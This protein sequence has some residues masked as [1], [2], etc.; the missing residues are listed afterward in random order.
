MLLFLKVF[1]DVLL[2]IDKY[3]IDV[4]YCYWCWYILLIIWLGYVLFYFM[5][6]SFNVVVLEIFVNG[7]FSCSDIGLLVILFYIIYGVLK[8]VFGIVSDCLNVCYFMGIGFIVMG[9]INILFGF[10]MLLWVFVVFWVLNVFFQGWGLLVCVCL[11]MVWYLC[12][13]CGGWWVLW[14]MVYNVGGVFIF[15]VMVVV[16]LYYGWCVGMMIVGC[17]VIVV[18]I[19]FCWWLCDCL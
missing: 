7:V 8:F 11:L 6:K 5:W 3:E 15:I 13:E 4:C 18:G 2:M 19:F 1:V 12:I 9:I 17:M 16:V 10:L 14:N